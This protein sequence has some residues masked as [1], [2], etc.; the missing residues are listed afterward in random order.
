M[1]EQ[2][3]CKACVNRHKSSD[4]KVRHHFKRHRKQSALAD[5]PRWLRFLDVDVIGEDQGT[6]V[7]G[8]HRTGIDRLVSAVCRGTAGLVLSLA[9]SCLTPIPFT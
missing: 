3:Q 7:D 2:L 8:L 6:S 4:F 1:T 9:G 5:R